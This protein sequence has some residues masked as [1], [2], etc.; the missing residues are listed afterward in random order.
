[1]FITYANP[2]EPPSFRNFR[3]KKI[4]KYIRSLHGND[5]EEDCAKFEEMM[6][7]LQMLRISRVVG[8]CS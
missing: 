7:E 8:S 3:S 1:M 5:I 2:S 6:K 4:I